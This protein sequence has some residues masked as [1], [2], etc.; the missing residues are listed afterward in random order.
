MNNMGV[1][2]ERKGDFAKAAEYYRKGFAIKEDTKAPLKA[3]VI[4]EINVARS[5][6][7]VGQYE[8]AVD[9]LKNSFKRLEDFPNLF[10]D[11]RSLLWE[12]MGKACLNQNNFPQAAAAFKKAI[13][14]RIQSSASDHSILGLVCMYAKSLLAVSENEKAVAEINKG[15]RLCDSIIQNTPTNPTIVFTYEKLLEA[16]FA[17][18]RR[19]AVDNTYEAGKKEFFRLIKVYEDLRNFNKREDVLLHFQ[20]FRQ[21]YLEMCENLQKVNSHRFC[22]NFILISLIGYKVLFVTMFYLYKKLKRK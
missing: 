16:N 9:L 19:E 14:F 21:R 8:E 13:A 20:K 6:L 4:S 3:L 5:I 12:T 1:L 7:E 17:L 22:D 15:L 10:S 11:A 2:Y 18:K